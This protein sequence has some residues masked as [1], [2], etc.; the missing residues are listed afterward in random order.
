MGRDTTAQKLTNVLRDQFCRTA[1]PD[2]LWSDGGPQ[3]TSSKFANFLVNW[4][5]SHITSS[6]HYPQSNGQAEAGNSY[7]LRG[8]ASQSIGKNSLDPCCNTGTHHVEK[9]ACP[10]PRNCLG[11][12]YKTACQP[13][14][15]HLHQSGRNHWKKLTIR[16]LVMLVMRLNKRTISIPESSLIS[17]LETT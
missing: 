6:P 9:M 3:F 17:K 14:A 2:V 13:T 10:Q 15:V 16:M 1:V 4:G 5:T 11:T 12:L 8:R 7:Q